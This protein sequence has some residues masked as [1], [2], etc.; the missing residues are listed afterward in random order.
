MF[1]CVCVFIIRR[2]LIYMYVV[3][4]IYKGVFSLQTLQLRNC[5]GKLEKVVSVF[6]YMSKNKETDF[7]RD[8]SP[9]H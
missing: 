8:P 9:S 6:L 7:T 1:A 4:F 2:V 3:L 5:F